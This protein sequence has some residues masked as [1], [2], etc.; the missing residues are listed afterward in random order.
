ML[1]DLVTSFLLQKL[2]SSC[3]FHSVSAS[4]S[5]ESAWCSLCH[6]LISCLLSLRNSSG[7]CGVVKVCELREM[8]YPASC[9]SFLYRSGQSQSHFTICLL[10]NIISSP[11]C[12]YHHKNSVEIFLK[13]HQ[14]CFLERFSQ[15]VNNVRSK[16]WDLFFTFAARGLN[17]N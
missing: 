1:P 17:A 5:M 12:S 6:P 16:M 9:F 7:S 15:A 2:R 3:K 11:V 14:S 13:E 8:S 10:Q 4:S